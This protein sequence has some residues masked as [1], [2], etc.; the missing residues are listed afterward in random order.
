MDRTPQR[1]TSNKDQGQK[2]VETTK[3]VYHKRLED[4]DV[5]GMG[6]L[7]KVSSKNSEKSSNS[8]AKKALLLQFMIDSGF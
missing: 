4:F 1:T 6:I 5:E 2:E 3:K 8:I 7:G